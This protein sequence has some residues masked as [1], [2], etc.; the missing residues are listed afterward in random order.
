M[1]LP[2]VC[3]KQWV[4]ISQDQFNELERRAIRNANGRAF[5]IVEGSATGAG[6]SDDIGLAS[7]GEAKSCPVY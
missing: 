5:L 2:E 1:W 7:F 4:I 6:I 3:Q